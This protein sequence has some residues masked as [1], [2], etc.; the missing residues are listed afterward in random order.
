MLRRGMFSLDRTRARGQSFLRGG[1]PSK[2][3]DMPAVL[4]LR[5]ANSPLSPAAQRD[6]DLFFAVELS[7]CNSLIWRHRR[8]AEFARLHA[9][10]DAAL[11]AMGL[12]REGLARY[13]FRDLLHS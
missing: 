7:G 11:A 8:E 2:G 10:P 4:Y 1:D 13:L 9:L 3:T 6:L 5:P 12:R